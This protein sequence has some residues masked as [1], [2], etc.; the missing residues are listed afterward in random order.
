MMAAH[1]AD[2]ATDLPPRESVQIEQPFLLVVEGKDDQLF[3][4]ALAR[5]IALENVQVIS[6]EGKT[7][8]R[9]RIKALAVGSGFSEV[10]SLGV[11]RDADTSPEAALQSVQGALRAANLP[12]PE[13]PLELT[14]GRPHVTVMIVPGLNKSGALEDLCLD[15]VKNEP[16]IECAEE[17]FECLKERSSGFPRN[18]SKAMVQVFLASREQSGK[19]LGEAACA[20]YWPWDYGAFDEI[21]RF[22]RLVCSARE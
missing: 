7:N 11:V 17:F 22:L 16:A 3:F 5:T 9:A 10:V 6:V 14:T 18:L 12:V 20:G 19:R 21:K 8:L 4:E 2:N 13:R 15:S 1:P